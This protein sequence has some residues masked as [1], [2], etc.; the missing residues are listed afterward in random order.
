M[1][2][3]DVE[4]ICNSVSGVEVVRPNTGPIVAAMANHFRLLARS[5]QKRKAV[6][7]K[8]ATA[9][10]ELSVATFVFAACPLPTPS[11]H[12]WLNWTFFLDFAPEIL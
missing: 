8:G 9:S 11:V 1:A 10:C 12:V 6:R 4:Q 5:Q 3:Y 2:F 7:T